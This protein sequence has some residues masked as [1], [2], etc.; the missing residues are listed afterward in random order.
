M[1]RRRPGVGRALLGML[2][3]LVAG[4]VP[5]PSTARA[6]T[7]RADGAISSSAMALA[8]DV[9]VVRASS[10]ERI[11]RHMTVR[12]RSRGCGRVG[13]ASAVA[14]GRRLLVTNR[15]VVAGADRIELNYWDGTSARARLETVAVDDD[16]A[17]VEVSLRL[18]T[19]ARLATID[20]PKGTSTMIVG[21][22]NG[23]QQRIVRGKLIE[24]APLAGHP[25]ASAVMRLSNPVV[26]GNSGGPVLNASGAVV[27][28]VFG[29]ETATG[30]GLAVPSSAVR[31]LVEHRGAGR[32]APSCP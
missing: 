11:A 21:F 13:T 15:H 25:D 5:T 23:G 29:I 3:L 22:P 2:L 30:N 27:G 18:P 16:L 8:A 12:V 4:C 9:P 17:L 26:P 28:V 14:V 6:G 19:V 7:A 32:R 1:P 10:L 31:R 20:A 24:Y